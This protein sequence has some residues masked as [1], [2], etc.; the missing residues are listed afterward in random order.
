MN[1]RPFIARPVIILFIF[2]A[3]TAAAVFGAF[4]SDN[5]DFGRA[6]FTVW[7]CLILGAWATAIVI[8]RAPHLRDTSWMHWWIAGLIAYLIHLWF[9][10]GVIFDWS[11]TA[12]FE[13]QGPIVASANFGLLALWILSA[14][15]ALLRRG[16]IGLHLATTG[17]FAATALL[18][19]LSRWNEPAFFG[20]LAIAALWLGALYYRVPF[21][22]RQIKAAGG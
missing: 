20:G 10:F 4:A 9:G 3:G 6:R 21:A 17:L 15:L 16:P 11:L 1:S 7:T 18:S 8:V 14:A 22:N 13:G 5:V 19:T 12:V 2:A